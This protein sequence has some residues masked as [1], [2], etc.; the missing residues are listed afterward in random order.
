MNNPEQSIQKEQSPAE[1][2][3]AAGSLEELI[4]VLQ[5]ISE[6]KDSDGDTLSGAEWANRVNSLV[7]FVNTMKEK[8]LAFEFEEIRKG[9]GRL[10]T[11][12]QGLRDK[13]FE[14]LGE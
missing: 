6:I 11:R 9:A 4:S 10:I 3:A 2:I 7:T 5:S 12:E 13:V 14:L 1:R 8:N